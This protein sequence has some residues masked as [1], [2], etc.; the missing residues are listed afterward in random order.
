MKRRFAILTALAP[1]TFALCLLAGDSGDVFPGRAV[2]LIRLSRVLSGFVVGGSLACAGAVFQ[3]LLRNP[4]AEPYVLGVSSGAGL[5][6][7]VAILTGMAATSFLALPLIAFVFAGITL[8]IVYALASTGGRTSVYGLILSGVIVSSICSSFLMFLITNAPVEGLHGIVWWMLGDLEVMS[9]P[10]LVAVSLFCLIGMA[11]IWLIAPEL[12]ALTLGQDVAH[13]VG[14]RTKRSI[15]LGL[16]L[17]TFV[18]AAAVSHSGLIGFVG[19][20]VPHVLRTIIGPDH[21]LLIPACALA[22]GIF[23]ALCDAVGRV[24]FAPEGMPVGV[25]TALI[26]G[27]FFLVILRRRRSDNWIE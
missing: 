2:M 18:T 10:L 21:R 13:F 26:G 9:Q 22:G 24:I 16:A 17:G 19:L 25:I 14:V 11:G 4:L 3:A 12:N 1:I 6:A 20:I 23:L 15:T 8:I 5:G 27:P 7:A